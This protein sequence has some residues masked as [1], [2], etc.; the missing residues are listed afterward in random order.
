M[1]YTSSA[2]STLFVKVNF[3]RTPY[4]NDI[5]SLRIIADNYE[6][7][8][9]NKAAFLVDINP[10]NVTLS[11]VNAVIDTLRIKANASDTVVKMPKPVFKKL[12]SRE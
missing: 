5:I 3:K 11:Q 9:S 12:L 8:T 1:F 2:S 4:N 7:F 10:D 6:G